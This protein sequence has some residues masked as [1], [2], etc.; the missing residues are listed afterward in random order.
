[1]HARLTKASLHGPARRCRF[2][3]R[4]FSS[5]TIRIDA[6]S[7]GNRNEYNGY[8]GVGFADVT[9]P[10]VAPALQTL[11]LPTDLLGETGAAS[12]SHE[13]VI[14]LNRLRAAGVPPRATP[15]PP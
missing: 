8:S 1:M 7:S 12:L 11:R 13:L 10:G 5:L 2:A 15:S 6:T 9:I 4:T 14:L 3:P